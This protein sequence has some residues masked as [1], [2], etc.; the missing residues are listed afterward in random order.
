[1]PTKDK[2]LREYLVCLCEAKI[3][4]EQA[5]DGVW[6]LFVCELLKDEAVKISLLVANQD[7]IKV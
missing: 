3:F 1:M 6:D 7:T 2:T 4:Y 5:P